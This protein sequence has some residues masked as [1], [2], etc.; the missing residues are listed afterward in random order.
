MIIGPKSLGVMEGIRSFS[1][2]KKFEEG[3][4]TLGYGQTKE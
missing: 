1:I 4:T 2:M 3:S